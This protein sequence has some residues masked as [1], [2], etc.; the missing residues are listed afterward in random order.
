[1]DRSLSHRIVNSGN[2]LDRLQR[3]CKGRHRRPSLTE[4]PFLLKGADWRRT[5]A[6]ERTYLVEIAFRY[7]RKRGFPYYRLKA[8]EIESEFRRLL[9]FDCTRIFVGDHLRGSNLGLRLANFFHHRMWSVHISRYRSPMD[10]FRDDKLL[11]LAIRRAF[12]LWPTRYSANASCLRRILKTFS[13]TAGVSNFKPVIAKAII[14]KYSRTGDVV[15]DFCA[16]YGGR[17]L[18]CLTLERRFIGIEP[19]K[20]Q[21]FGLERMI[22]SMSRF[23]GCLTSAQILHG[24]AEEQ[25]TKLPSR[26]AALVFSSP[27]YFDWE[28]YASDSSQSFI[29]YK[30]YE[31]WMDKFLQPVIAESFRVL[32]NRGYLVLN[33]SNGKRNPTPQHVSRLAKTFGFV[34]TKSHRMVLPKVPYLHPRNGLS[35]KCECVLVFVRRR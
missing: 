13:S 25:L 5:T 26:S 19:C 29:R 12:I 4:T 11:R 9:L 16:G 35:E 2:L 14:A 27:P 21:V 8:Q 22:R 30:T 15:V 28:Q 1:M 10:V 7:W 20:S 24:R 3:V 34:L 23:E 31:E 17:L 32:K 33:V 18:G 6:S